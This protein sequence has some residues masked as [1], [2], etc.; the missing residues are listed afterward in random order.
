MGNS[1]DCKRSEIV[2]ML[3]AGKKSQ[4]GGCTARLPGV[5]QV[6]GIACRLVA[7][8][9]PWLLS[10]LAASTFSSSQEGLPSPWPLQ[11]E[12]GTF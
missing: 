2:T 3:R 9:Q 1:P 8:T 7:L 6:L 11:H 5:C 4:R 12:Q 10:F